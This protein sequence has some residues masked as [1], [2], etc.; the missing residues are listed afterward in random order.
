MPLLPICS[1]TPS[2]VDADVE[3]LNISGNSSQPSFSGDVYLLTCWGELYR[4]TVCLSVVRWVMYG[5]GGELDGRPACWLPV[6]GSEQVVAGQTDCRPR[7]RPDT[8]AFTARPPST[9]A[10]P[11]GRCTTVLPTWSSTDE[12]HWRHPRSVSLFLQ[13]YD[14]VLSTH[15]LGE[16][17]PNFGNPPP[18]SLGQIYCSIKNRV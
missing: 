5:C 7:G 4:L 10:V 1:T 12:L 3:G 15:H 18:R 6:P 11:R 2:R 8:G 9:T 13:K 16:A 17:S 14:T